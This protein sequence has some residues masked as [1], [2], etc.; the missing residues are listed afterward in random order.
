MDLA[1]SLPQ[2]ERRWGVGARALLE[3]GFL[4]TSRYLTQTNSSRTYL[5]PT[6]V[7]ANRKVERL[8]G[9]LLR[10][11]AGVAEMRHRLGAP[12]SSWRLRAYRIGGVEHPDAVWYREGEPWAIEYDVG[13]KRETVLLK[14]RAFGRL[15]AGQVWGAATPKRVGFLTGLLEAPVLLAPWV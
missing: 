13:Y 14:A 10:H 2:V 6:F 15:F 9:P 12:P 8:P 11:L 5:L 7:V 4:L 1:L 3:E